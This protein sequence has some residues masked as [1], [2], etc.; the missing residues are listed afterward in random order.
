MEDQIDKVAGT[1]TTAPRPASEIAEQHLGEIDW[2]SPTE[3]YCHCPGRERHSSKD[4]RRDC[5]LYL[6]KVLTLYCVHASCGPAVEEANRKLRAAILNG[7]TDGAKPRR[8]TGEDRARLR[9]REDR[10]RIR[11]RAAKSLPQI[12]TNHQWTYDQITTDSPVQLKG[13]P[14]NHWH[15]LL[16][17]FQ[18]MD[19][20]WIG[21]TFDSGK[22]EHARH[23]KSTA[24][25]LKQSKAPGPFICPASFKNTSIA[26]SNENI[27]ARRFLV[28]E[29][30]TL[31]KDEVGAIFKWLKEKVGLELVAMVD[32][33]GKSLH[34]WFRYPAQEYVVDELKLIL[35]AL[36][37][38]PKLFTPSQPVRLPGALRDGKYQKLVYLATDGLEQEVAHE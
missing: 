23:F 37:C 11:K 5:I 13:S 24:E 28:V 29:S 7:S 34:G 27:L 1:P 36:Q 12:L 22:P 20:V 2:I 21:D 15:L 17:K 33:A 9:Q 35:P 6:D 3:G 10:E 14:Q 38:D 25:W 26:R 32:T 18:P 30:D 8:L 19:T 16:H 31:K 4:G